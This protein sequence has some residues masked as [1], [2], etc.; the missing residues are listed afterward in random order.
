M[1]RRI[2]CPLALCLL[3]AGCSTVAD[4]ASPPPSQSPA[5][6][7]SAPGNSGTPRPAPQWG[8]QTYMTAFAAEG[9]E[10]PVFSPE[11]RLPKIENAAGIP[12]YEAINAFYASTLDDLAASAAELSGWAVDDY[13]TAQIVGYPFYNYVDTESY[14]LT[15]E[16]AGLVSILRSHYSNSGGPYPTLYPMADTFDLTTGARLTFAD[17]FT[18]PEPEAQARVLNAVLALN[19]AG[20]YSGAVLD[21]EALRN[22]YSPQHF[23]LTEDS[24]VC[25]FPGGDLPNAVG[26]PTFAVPYTDLEDILASWE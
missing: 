24:L 22:A 1:F 11:Y 3:L 19:E 13:K 25:Y 6:E 9:R 8:E 23:Y 14:E 17:L 16:T 2:L 10:E 21:A 4:H 5:P 7:V 20:A 12:A 15:M 18:V 26:S